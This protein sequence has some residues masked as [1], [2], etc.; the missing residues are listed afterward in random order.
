M[1]PSGEHPHSD[2][3]RPRANQLILSLVGHSNSFNLADDWIGKVDL[4]FRHFVPNE[5]EK[6]RSIDGGHR[7]IRGPM[8]QVLNASLKVL[9][10]N[11][12]QHAEVVLPSENF[13]RPPY[14]RFDLGIPTRRRVSVNRF[15]SRIYRDIVP[16]VPHRIFSR[17]LSILNVSLRGIPGSF[18]RKSV[19]C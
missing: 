3:T 17:L 15:L 8:S 10:V 11:G 1:T 12:V 16:M 7:K 6:V 18:A 13:A 9:E 19:N 2:E 4:T 5:N 14:S